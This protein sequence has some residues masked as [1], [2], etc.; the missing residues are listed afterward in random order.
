MTFLIFTVWF[1]AMGALMTW[2]G[3]RYFALRPYMRKHGVKPR[4]EW[5]AGYHLNE[6]LQA[7]RDIA[8][9]LDENPWFLRAYDRAFVI[10][11]AAGAVFLLLWVFAQ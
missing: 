2:M 8:E 10:M 3:L 11:I 5:I 6:D 7:V 4:F 1:V 9:R